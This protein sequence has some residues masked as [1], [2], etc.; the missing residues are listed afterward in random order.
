[1]C[2]DDIY[3]GVYK[4][5]LQQAFVPVLTGA[6]CV[7]AAVFEKCWYHYFGSVDS[8]ISLGWNRVFVHIPA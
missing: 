4:C 1:M 6:V 5:V 7:L 3:S 8:H 2:A